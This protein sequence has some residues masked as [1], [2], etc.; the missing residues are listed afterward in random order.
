LLI[1]PE[2]LLL[3]RFEDQIQ[4]H[5]LRER[6]RLPAVIGIEFVYH[7][8]GACIDDDGGVTRLGLQWLGDRYPD[9]HQRE[10]EWKARQCSGT[11]RPEAAR[12]GNPKHMEPR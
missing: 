12:F 7:R 6:S 4:R 1:A 3:E 9:Y 11:H 10:N 5:H 8:A 2:L